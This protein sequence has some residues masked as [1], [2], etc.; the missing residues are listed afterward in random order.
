[1]DKPEAS[2]SEVPPPR[3][4]QVSWL[5]LAVF[6]TSQ[7]RMGPD[8]HT[9]PHLPTG[10]LTRKSRGPG[11]WCSPGGPLSRKVR[12]LQKTPTHA[13]NTH[14][15]THQNKT[16]ICTQTATLSTHSMHEHT[17]Q[18]HT[19]TLAKGMLAHRDRET[20]TYHS[21]H[22]QTLIPTRACPHCHSCTKATQVSR[23]AHTCTL[24]HIYVL[25]QSHM[26]CHT[27]HTQGHIHI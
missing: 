26:Y 22:V 14:A 12:P 19:H 3:A 16:D 13:H 9:P 5:L 17:T 25:R 23:H 27:I 1:M 20:H 11:P 2:G 7:A 8:L 10:E 6:H 18:K 4:D 24:T 21:T 15:H